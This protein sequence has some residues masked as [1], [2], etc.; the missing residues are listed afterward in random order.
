MI[1]GFPYATL[2]VFVGFFGQFVFFMRFVVQWIATE[3]NK[4]VTIPMAF[5]YLSV[6]GTIIL[7]FYSIHIRDVVFTTAQFLS[8]LIY[9]RNIALELK[10]TRSGSTEK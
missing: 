7:L 3:R 10:R 5:W 6:S 2:W 9:G 8:L 4:R 1:F